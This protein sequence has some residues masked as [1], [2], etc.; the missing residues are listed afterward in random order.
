MLQGNREAQNSDRSDQEHPT[1]HQPIP[2]DRSDQEHPSKHQ[3]DQ[4]IPR[5]SDQEHPSKHQPISDVTCKP[6]PNPIAS[7]S[8]QR[9]QTQTDM[10][11]QNSQT[12][13]S[14]IAS[15]CLQR[16]QIHSVQQTDIEP[17]LHLSCD[18]IPCHHGCHSTNQS[19][20]KHC[21]GYHHKHQ[22]DREKQTGNN[23][24]FKGYL[25]EQA[26]STSEES[27]FEE[28]KKR[29]LKVLEREM[30]VQASSDSEGGIDIKHKHTQPTPASQH[31]PER[32][33]IVM[34]KASKKKTRNKTENKKKSTKKNKSEKYLS[35][36][37]EVQ[38]QIGSKKCS[39]EEDTD[40]TS[41]A[42]RTRPTR[43]GQD[44]SRHFPQP[45]YHSS[46]SSSRLTST[47][48]QVCHILICN[49]Y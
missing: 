47:I 5:V 1:K 43:K 12:Y 37:T 39:V 2:S 10:D 11:N 17:H 41:Q 45:K 6:A 34:Q 28:Y 4:P 16:K 32:D 40:Y 18:I 7:P 8:L 38:V 30:R 22:H 27:E 29:H 14:P 21:H 44:R 42:V 31:I 23:R 9:K 20:H 48:G 25:S 26:Q 35:N 46:P 36:A 19:N 24:G 3:P 13:H 15:P 33:T 49:L